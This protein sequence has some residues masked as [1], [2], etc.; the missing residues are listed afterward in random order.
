[1]NHEAVPSRRSLHA[2]LW[3][4][5]GSGG[6]SQLWMSF[7][8][9]FPVMHFQPPESYLAQMS[10]LTLNLVDSICRLLHHSYYPRLISGESD[11]PQ[12]EHT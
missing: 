11:A 3:F 8:N 5:E 7:R 4:V 1:M 2:L 12:V 10:G 9:K 6:K